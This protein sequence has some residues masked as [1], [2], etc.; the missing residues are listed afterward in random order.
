M[1]AWRLGVSSSHGSEAR[2]LTKRSAEDFD[3]T[4]QIGTKRI[5]NPK[6]MA[7]LPAGIVE[8]YKDP[9]AQ[10]KENDSLFL[11]DDLD[12]QNEHHNES[13]RV[14]REVKQHETRQVSTHVLTALAP[15]NDHT[16]RAMPLPNR[17]T[18][19]S[20]DV[21]FRATEHS[22]PP[23]PAAPKPW[24]KVYLYVGE[25]KRARG[26]KLLMVELIPSLASF[27]SQITN[28][29]YWQL[30]KS[31]PNC[32]MDPV[33]HCIVRY[34]I[35]GRDSSA[36]IEAQD[37]RAWKAALDKLQSEGEAGGVILTGH[38]DVHL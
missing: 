33:R 10:Y 18:T 1:A 22:L 11:N 21:W 25:E 9:T 15:K 26:T 34:G 29:F 35:G 3:S 12:T 6:V 4:D 19:S 20:L 2:A 31:R 30:E 13:G 28:A 36:R 27:K 38:V 5:F 23:A 37:D 8:G 17:L 7:M 24:L 16:Q 14:P 32:Q